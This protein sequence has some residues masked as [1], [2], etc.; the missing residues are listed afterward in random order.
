NLAAHADALGLASAS[1]G[2]GIDPAVARPVPQPAPHPA[3]PLH[4]LDQPESLEGR[5]GA[6]QDE[7][8]ADPLERLGVGAALDQGYPGARSGEQHRGRA[9]GEACAND[10]HVVI[11]LLP[12]HP[13]FRFANG[14]DEAPLAIR[15]VSGSAS[16]A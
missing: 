11:R 8:A 1:G 16:S 6:R 9:A 13:A 2:T 4:G 5:P 7:V 14:T 12:A 10:Y 15:L 3:G